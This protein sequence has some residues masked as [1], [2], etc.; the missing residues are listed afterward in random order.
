V[1]VAG[2]GALGT[3]LAEVLARAGVGRLVL[4]DNDTFELCNLQRQALL[5]EADIGLPKARVVA[6][7]LTQVNS[8]V[9]VS[10]EVVR[11]DAKNVEG[12]VAD[13]DLV[14]D[15]FDNLPSRYL[16]N[17]AC[18]KHG[19]PWVF[20]AVAGTYG[21]TMPILP[22]KGPCLRCLFPFPAPD[23]VVL[24]AQNAGVI[25]TLPRAIAAVEGTQ[26]IKILLGKEEAS[27][28]LI[29]YDIWRDDFAVQTIVRNENC[30]CCGKGCYAFLEPTSA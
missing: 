10:Y 3:N 2:C 18:V 9:D 27:I 21:I 13:V 17:D 12:L 7:A 8:T 20:A 24:T 23:E 5:T 14:L 30:P 19:I 15:G 25:N 28:H 26:G 11:I 22:R 4:V 1:L 29:T 6:Q 16:L